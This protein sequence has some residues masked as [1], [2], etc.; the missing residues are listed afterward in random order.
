MPILHN[1][2]IRSVENNTFHI[3][4]GGKQAFV[5]NSGNAD[6]DL[7]GNKVV[8]ELRQPGEQQ[9]IDSSGKGTFNASNNTVEM[10]QAAGELPNKAIKSDT[11]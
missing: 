5:K 11:Q 8:L 1:I 7:K 3:K 2:H 6:F 9:F 4:G 10:K